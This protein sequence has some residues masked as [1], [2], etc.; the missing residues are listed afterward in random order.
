MADPLDVERLEVLVH[1]V[2]SPVAALS[3]IAETVATAGVDGETRADLVRLVLAACRGIERLVGDRAVASVRSER[4][5]ITAL[6]D[7]AVAT[8]RLRGLAV[9]TAIDGDAGFVE[10]DPSRL[11]QALDNLLANALTHADGTGVRVTAATRGSTVTIVVA[12]RG[13]GIPAAERGRIFEPGVRLDDPVPGS[14]L[15]LAVTR[16]VVE[17]HGGRLAVAAT[18]GGGAT[19]I[20]ELPSAPSS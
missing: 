10:A 8:A 6:V 12:D 5:D 7:D 13:P 1:E 18:E 17:A 14:G 16:A 3:A 15:G 2:R 11:R 4:V 20:V 19:F 9:E